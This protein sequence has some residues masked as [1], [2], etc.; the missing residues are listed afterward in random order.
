M[1]AAAWF[2]RLPMKLPPQPGVPIR[3]LVPAQRYPSG[4]PYAKE[5]P[6]APFTYARTS[7]EERKSR[8][9]QSWGRV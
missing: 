4:V 8:A 3:N 5:A 2:E 6:Y 7:E 1:R 9:R